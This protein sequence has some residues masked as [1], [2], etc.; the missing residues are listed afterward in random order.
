MFRLPSLIPLFVSVGLLA[1]LVFPSGCASTKGPPAGSVPSERVLAAWMRKAKDPAI[2]WVRMGMDDNNEI[3]YANANRVNGGKFIELPF[4]TVGALPYPV[5]EQLRQDGKKQRILFDSSSRHNWTDFG[6]AVANNTIPLKIESVQVAPRHVKD[7][8][9][10]ARSIAGVLRLGNGRV[11]SAVVNVRPVYETVGPLDRGVRG[12]KWRPNLVVGNELLAQFQTVHFDFPRKRL[13]LSSTSPY[14]VEPDSGAVDVPMKIYKGAAT[15]PAKI[16]GSGQRGLIVD[17][18]GNFAL[19]V[20]KPSGKTA[21][22]QIGELVFDSVPVVSTS[23]LGLGVPE[24]PRVGLQLLRQ[25]RLTFEHPPTP[26]GGATNW[27][28]ILENPFIEEGGGKLPGRKF[29]KR[30]DGSLTDGV[31][32]TRSPDGVTP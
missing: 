28:M 29:M 14:T 20:P 9:A 31:G 15:V 8:L 25:Y 30:W 13:V 6:S 17:T 24:V 1:C 4:E 32:T 5:V 22:L 26:E 18:A 19:A 12:K 16:N 11:E 3:I 10:S 27:R 2:H 7:S 23:S 21:S